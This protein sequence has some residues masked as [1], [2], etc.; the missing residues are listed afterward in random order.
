MNRRRLVCGFA[1]VA[2]LGV[3]GVHT[4][5]A[6]ES[7]AVDHAKRVVDLL[8]QDKFE[9]VAREF[10][11]QVASLLSAA[12][13]RDVWS[14][15]RQQA[16]TFTSF[17]DQRVTTPA[18]GMTAVVLGCQFEKTAMNVIVAFDLE[19][20]I[21]GL[22]L[23]PRA[24]PGQEV[25]A[26]PTSTRFKEES[27]TVGTGE[28]ALPGTLSMPVGRIAAAIVLVHGSGPN[29]RDET[30][31]PNK[32]FRELAWGL[33]DRGIAVL[34]YEKRTRRYA[35]KIAGNQNF[36]VREETI[37]DALLAA[38]LLRAHDR[39]D[40]KRVFVLG[41][42]LGGTLAP[43]IAAEDRSLAGLIIL[44]GATRP[45]M[46]VAREQL[47]YLASL[48]P[49]ASNPE[50]RLQM[51]RRSAPEAYWK[52]LDAYK[53]AQAA[54]T[55]AV[56]MLILQGERDYQVTLEDLRGWRDALDGHAGVTIKSY[57]T[58]NHL[59]LPGE[60]KSTPSEYERAGHIPDFVLDD[61]A[62]WINKI[63]KT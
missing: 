3:G 50:D 42:S 47:A 46:E 9:D 5:D 44:A 21:A 34:R 18:A 58:L 45:L 37:E 63:D 23:I 25:T 19:N 39:I 49:G 13:L 31:G 16:G 54:A 28:W 36:T 38:T 4:G 40:P 8:R 43:R 59:F 2:V 52:D 35:G 12:Q 30:L 17:I 20:K 33:A 11:A 26:S 6:Q 48:T 51:L 10:N 41:H 22:R 60:G 55:L 24:A 29:D 15:V 32:P 57:P 7:P 53:A 1:F 56:P 14:T 27:V 61:I 62:D